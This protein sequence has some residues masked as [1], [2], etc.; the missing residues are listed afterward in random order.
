MFTW[1]R[2]FWCLK[3]FFLHSFPKNKG[4]SLRPVR[5]QCLRWLYILL[6]SGRCPFFP[7][8]LASQTPNIFPDLQFWSLLSTLASFLNL[9]ILPIILGSRWSLR[10][11][12]GY[13]LPAPS[14][15]D[16]TYSTYQWLLALSHISI[17]FATAS[18]SIEQQ[19]GQHTL[20]DHRVLNLWISVRISTLLSFMVRA[21]HITFE[22]L[23]TLAISFLSSVLY[24]DRYP[25]SSPLIHVSSF[26]PPAISVELR[27][28]I[29]KGTAFLG[30]Q[31]FL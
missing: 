25:I 24:R 1:L 2:I 20:F 28:A 21:Y 22:L 19:S 26:Y 31:Q 23:K 3:Y 5:T 11:L 15:Y 17:D 8:V 7:L 10:K 29:I 16:V 6:P 13:F 9:T 30:V 14:V 4:V 27:K 12:L 18:K